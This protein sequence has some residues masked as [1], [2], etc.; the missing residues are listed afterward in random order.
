MPPPL[1]LSSCLFAHGESELVRSRFSSHSF[2]PDPAYNDSVYGNSTMPYH[3]VQHQQSYWHPHPPSDGFPVAPGLVSSLSA[4]LPSW[5]A[6]FPASPSHEPPQD[7]VASTPKGLLRA[8]GAFSPPGPESES[9]RKQPLSQLSAEDNHPVSDAVIAALPTA[10][11]DL[12][13][14]TRGT[15]EAE[16]TLTQTSS[17]RSVSL[18]SVSQRPEEVDVVEASPEKALAHPDF[19][20]D[21]SS[22][23]SLGDA[24][25]GCPNT[26]EITVIN[27]MLPDQDRGD[28]SASLSQAFNSLQMMPQSFKGVNSARPPVSS[29]APNRH[30]LERAQTSSRPCRQWLDSG[31]TYC[32]YGD[33]CR[34]QHPP[35]GWVPRA[36]EAPATLKHQLWRPQLEPQA[37]VESLH[38]MGRPSSHGPYGPMSPWLPPPAPPLRSE[39]PLE[40]QD[41]Y[42]SAEDTYPPSYP[43]QRPLPQS[44]VH[45]TPHNGSSGGYPT[46]Y[47]PTYGG[48]N[49][50]AYHTPHAFDNTV[51]GGY[52][53]PP[54]VRRAELLGDA[55]E[56]P[57][58]HQASLGYGPFSS[59][60]ATA[61]IQL[62]RRELHVLPSYDGVLGYQQQ[63]HEQLLKQQEMQQRATADER[64][65]FN[66]STAAEIHPD[67][68]VQNAVSSLER[69]LQRLQHETPPVMAPMMLP[70][71]PLLP[72]HLDL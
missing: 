38:G 7:S 45:F 10:S 25:D 18:M 9:K 24:S 55:L 49:Y 70:P 68:E 31:N 62:P 42:P 15:S 14:T 23:S 46:E 44:Y 17:F 5:R 54:M 72:R 4:R 34:F 12:A 65:R 60:Y 20:D 39:H 21:C 48:V 43:H 11:S 52:K 50:R 16:K 29:A 47:S 66:L 26:S 59:H 22:L 8:S 3:S 2:A 64:R 36:P 51:S 71:K 67:G 19:R 32:A 1:V 28:R 6:V 61:S 13:Y 27:P 30:A 33:L 35:C 69:S 37:G 40:T 53:P 57:V 41:Y 63:P 58:P 56:L